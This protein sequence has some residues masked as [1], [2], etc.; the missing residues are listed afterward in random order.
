MTERQGVIR[1]EGRVSEPTPNDTWRVQL[2]NGHM[3]TARLDDKLR[4]SPV[5]IIP[6]DR[7][8][9]ELSPY[10]LTRGRIVERIKQMK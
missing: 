5:R 3:V 9:V 10:D 4:L 1:V 7:V 8:A 6:G 2:D